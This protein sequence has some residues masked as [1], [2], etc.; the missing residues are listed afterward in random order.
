METKEKESRFAFVNQQGRVSDASTVLP[1]CA[2]DSFKPVRIRL[3]GGETE[4][5]LRMNM[6]K[7]LDIAVCFGI[8]R[9][10]VGQGEWKNG[11]F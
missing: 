2:N 11:D 9:F 4:V 7:K 5:L 1:I 6:V 3:I 8:D 10:K